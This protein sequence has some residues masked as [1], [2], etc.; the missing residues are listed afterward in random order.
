[1]TTQATRTKTPPP[2]VLNPEQLKTSIEEI[3]AAGGAPPWN[4]I[5][6][7]N[8]RLTATFIYQLPGTKND[9]HYH[10]EDEWWYI[11]E[12]ELAWEMEGA[13]EP[14]YVKAGDFVFAPANRYHLI[15]VLGDQPAIR[16]GFS[17]T[18]EGH[19]HDR[20]DPPPPAVI[21]HGNLPPR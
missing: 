4:R 16:I 18:G 6:V 19:R 10:L 11:A 7:R 8:D 12:G 2:P 5:L 15:H 20:Q 14:I 1:M 13:E 21:G 9:H 17:Y 3:K